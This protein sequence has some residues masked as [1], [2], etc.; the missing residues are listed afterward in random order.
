MI[1][2]RRRLPIGLRARLGLLAIGAIVAGAGCGGGGSAEERCVRQNLNPGADL[3]ECNFKHTD[4]AKRDLAD[5]DLSD[6][7]LDRASFKAS[8][9]SGADFSRADLTGAYL[10]A[11]NLT[12]ADFSEATIGRA[13]FEDAKMKGVNLEG[14]KAVA[15]AK[16]QGAKG[17]EDASLAA[18]F[19]IPA[20]KV[21]TYL[22]QH[23]I[24]L[25]SSEAIKNG[26]ANVCGGGSLANAASKP[27]GTLAVYGTGEL[28]RRNY[29]PPRAWRPMATRYVYRVACLSDTENLFETCTYS[30]A[31]D[32]YSVRRV[33]QV[34]TI[35]VRDASTGK[36]IASTSFTGDEPRA[37]PDKVEFGTAELWGDVPEQTI[38][39]WLQ[40]YRGG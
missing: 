23:G 29:D 14:T 27:N 37:C 32:L 2:P 24:E 11:A 5:A 30:F 20:D 28:D 19:G 33:Q 13:T 18:A 31:G 7:Q 6:A 16:L 35:V 38:T 8:D 22:G 34:L 21:P 10:K 25:E 12:G 39:G 1:A 26:L 36:E 9:L 40:D 17:L 15:S 3:S 4:L